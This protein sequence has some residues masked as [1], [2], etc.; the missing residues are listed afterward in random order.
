MEIDIENPAQLLSHV[1]LQNKQ[2][3]DKVVKTKQYRIDG[4][5]EATVYFN[6]VKCPAETLE[7]VLKHFVEC[8]KK[9]VDL[10]G[11]NDKV[12]RKAEQILKTHT[13]NVLEKLSV[14]EDISCRP[15]DFIKEGWDL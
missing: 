15:E 7:E 2:V 1:L 14:L 11:F 4:E 3:V 9:E 8:V 13:D 12:Q 10:G 5:I 6:G